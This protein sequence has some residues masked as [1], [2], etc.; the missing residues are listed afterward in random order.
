ML[1]YHYTVVITQL[2]IYLVKC[3]RKPRF[4]E[5]LYK[6]NKLKL[7]CC[8]GPSQGPSLGPLLGAS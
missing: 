8:K 2:F 4:R 1:L 5:A 3:P 7:I 6:I